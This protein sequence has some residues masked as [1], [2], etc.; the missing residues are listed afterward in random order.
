MLISLFLQYIWYVFFFWLM[1]CIYQKG[2][3]FIILCVMQRTGLVSTMKIAYLMEVPPIVL[4]D[5]LFTT[6][7]R[8]VYY[9]RPLMEMWIKSTQP[10]HDSPSGLCYYLFGELPSKEI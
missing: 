6:G 1:H 7:N 8:E 9:P 10:P 2:T 5:D 4:I 3:Q